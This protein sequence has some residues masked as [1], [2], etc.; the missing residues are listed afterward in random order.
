MYLTI[1]GM[2][3]IIITVTRQHPIDIDYWK[4]I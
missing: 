1:K 2:K 4:G 3:G